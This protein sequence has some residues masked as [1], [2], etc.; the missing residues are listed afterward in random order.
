M[1]AACFAPHRPGERA[2]TWRGRRGLARRAPVPDEGALCA[3]RSC[4]R[5]Q[6]GP[7][8]RGPLAAKLSVLL[9]Q[10][11]GELLPSPAG[12]A[13]AEKPAEKT[14]RGR[15]PRGTPNAIRRGGG[16]WGVKGLSP[17]RLRPVPTD[18]SPGKQP[19]PPPMQ[20]VIQYQAGGPSKLTVNKCPGFTFR[21]W[22]KF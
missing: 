1:P 21:H 14:C 8:S 5:T 18:W 9:L 19:G 22:T 17:V 15:G 2:S 12:C 11:Q 16:A 13:P 6:A 20:L 3:R 7:R 10:A 4:G